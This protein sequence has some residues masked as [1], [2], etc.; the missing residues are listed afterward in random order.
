MNVWRV[1]GAPA[2]QW[3]WSV[4]SVFAA[5]ITGI[6]RR[7]TQAFVAKI[8]SFAAC[9]LFTKKGTQSK[10]PGSRDVSRMPRPRHFQSE[11]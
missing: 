10:K 6:E 7:I 9:E 8:D 2:I 4:A 5:I 3:M 11:T 1:T